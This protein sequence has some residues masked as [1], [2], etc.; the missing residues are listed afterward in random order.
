MAYTGPP[1][2]SGTGSLGPKCV[3]NGQKCPKWAVL[4]PF[5]GRFGPFWGRFGAVLELR[6]KQKSQMCTIMLIWKLLRPVF[7]LY[8]MDFRQFLVV[9]VFFG[10]GA[11]LEVFCGLRSPFLFGAKFHLPGDVG[12]VWGVFGSY[13]GLCG[14]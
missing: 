2:P 11:L 9:W 3:S 7:V 5:W 10:V 13:L 1:E 8:W 14:W 4:G 6:Y 12:P